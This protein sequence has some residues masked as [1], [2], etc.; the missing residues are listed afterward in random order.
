MQTEATCLSCG[1]ELR[2]N[3]HFCP[4][5]GA[6]VRSSAATPVPEPGDEGQSCIHC[7]MRTNRNARFCRSCGQSLDPAIGEGIVSTRTIKNT[8]E[9]SGKTLRVLAII[10]S[11]ILLSIGIATL[12]Y[13]TTSSDD[14]SADG[15]VALHLR[16]LASLAI[17]SGQSADASLTTPDRRLSIDVPAGAFSGNETLTISAVKAKLPPY[18]GAFSRGEVFDVSPA[19]QSL[20]QRPLSLTFSLD[21]LELPEISGANFE[22][23]WWHEGLQ[24]WIRMPSGIDRTARTISFS[25]PHLSAYA[26]F[27]RNAETSAPSIATELAFKGDPELELPAGTPDGQVGGA[28][29]SLGDSANHQLLEALLKFQ[30]DYQLELPG[31]LKERVNYS[32]Y[33]HSGTMGEGKRILN[34]PAGS[35]EERIFDLELYLRS[36][37]GEWTPAAVVEYAGRR[38]V[39][40]L[41]DTAITAALTYLTGG[42]PVAMNALMEID[43]WWSILPGASGGYAEDY[44]KHGDLVEQARKYQNL[45]ELLRQYRPLPRSAKEAA[46]REM[47]RANELRKNA[48]DYAFHSE[49]I[50]RV[51]DISRGYQMSGAL[52]A[53]VE[54]YVGG[55]LGE[56]E[57]QD[58][59]KK[60]SAHFRNDETTY[61]IWRG[62]C[63]KERQILLQKTKWHLEV[64][65]EQLLLIKGL[66]L[67]LKAEDRVTVEVTETDPPTIAE[68]EI[69]NG[70]EPAESALAAQDNGG[71]PSEWFRGTVPGGWTVSRSERKSWN[72]NLKRVIAAKTNNCPEQIASGWVN[73]K[74]DSHSP[75]AGKDEILKQLRGQ[76]ESSGWYPEEEGV[77]P[78]T[79]GNFSGW[80]LNSTLKY[81]TGFGNPMAGYRGGTAHFHGY[82]FL[83]E[84]G[85]GRSMEINF[86]VFSGSCWDNSGE[87]NARAQVTSA[88]AEAMTII[89]GLTLAP[90]K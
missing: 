54:R 39:D 76:L 14:E 61:R 65:A 85:T 9:K 80:L 19:N 60:L 53:G 49:F 29:L 28:T 58:L 24:Q 10:S 87:Q 25:V 11:V 33:Y 71:V 42:V 2:R 72:A 83:T 40:E 88:R 56:Q 52:M 18:S 74:L 90:V 77:S 31:D 69:S 35:P 17:P 68:D 34:D 36:R 57:R 43:D 6:V 81:K 22:A 26:W 73:A 23:A 15:K 78:F 67:Q 27:E 64:I 45:R 55:L 86:S 3:A 82:L 89:R 48:V 44:L 7:G 37:H 5:C 41:R 8:F 1:N 47:E 66:T 70:T 16:S 13:V 32:G 62:R 75:L 20:L 59:E 50:V 38:G 21:G 46:L 63:E 51:R 84:A 79:L 12:R 4:G 30:T